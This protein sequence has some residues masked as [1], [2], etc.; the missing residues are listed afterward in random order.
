MLLQSIS[1]PE[2][3]T[4][5]ISDIQQAEGSKKAT[6]LRY[7]DRDAIDRIEDSLCTRVVPVLDAIATVL[8]SKQQSEVIAVGL[9]DDSKTQQILLSLASNTVMEEVT[10]QHC[11]EI[12]NRL[13]SIAEGYAEHRRLLGINTAEME[14]TRCDSPELPAKVSEDLDAQITALKENLYKFS[15]QKWT[16]KLFKPSKLGVTRIDSF[17]KWAQDQDG[18]ALGRYANDPQN[19]FRR[20]RLVRKGLR[21]IH[22]LV[23]HDGKRYVMPAETGFSKLITIMDGLYEAI[24]EIFRELGTRGVIMLDMMDSPGSY[25]SPGSLLSPV[26]PFPFPKSRRLTFFGL[27]DTPSLDTLKRCSRFPLGSYGWFTTLT[28]PDCGSAIFKFLDIRDV[29]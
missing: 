16:H 1:A 26:S 20:L 21:I 11:R 4:C 13:K 28:L 27:K 17:D 22:R 23:H 6:Q 12:W 10:L 18:G 19:F 9:Q 2:L 7:K 3:L 15:F 8:V 14:D 29:S 5:L 24:R 25:I